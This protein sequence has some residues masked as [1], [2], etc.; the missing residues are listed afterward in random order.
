[1]PAVNWITEEEAKQIKFQETL[2]EEMA[3]WAEE[4]LGI[5]SEKAETKMSYWKVKN[6]A[7]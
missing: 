5:N 2:V 1:M 7:D 3:Y 4:L 6:Q